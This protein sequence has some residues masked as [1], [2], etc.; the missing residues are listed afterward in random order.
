MEENAASNKRDQHLPPSRRGVQRRDVTTKNSDETS[1]EL[2]AEEE[3]QG[4]PAPPTQKR[5]PPKSKST[6]PVDYDDSPMVDTWG[7]DNFPK[8]VQ[9]TA[10]A[11]MEDTKE[12]VTKV[13]QAEAAAAATELEQAQLAAAAATM[14]VSLTGE[15]GSGEPATSDCSASEDNRGPRRS[16]RWARKGTRGPR[17]RARSTLTDGVEAE[18]Y[19]AD[20]KSRPP[21]GT[22]LMG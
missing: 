3:L 10:R 1:E 11:V 12:A 17:T 7:D 22:R 6:I 8:L 15:Q 13:V 9:V 20:R 5:A 18:Q 16:R 21:R 4:E 19:K 14:V 2:H